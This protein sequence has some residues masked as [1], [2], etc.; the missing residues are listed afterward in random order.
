MNVVRAA[1][2]DW[3]RARFAP[4]GRRDNKNRA[5]ASLAGRG[6]AIEVVRTTRLL[7]FWHHDQGVAGLACVA[8][9]AFS[10]WSAWGAWGTC[11][12]W[13]R[14]CYGWAWNS[15]WH[16]NGR[17][18]DGWRWVHSGFFACGQGCYCNHCCQQGGH[19]HGGFLL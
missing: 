16:F 13:N 9:L 6:G 2:I 17:G 18:N 5:T 3:G 4:S 19:F 14:N 7:L 8:F 12:T 11:R 15:H 10:T 1:I